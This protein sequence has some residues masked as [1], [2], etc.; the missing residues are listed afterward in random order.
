MEKG[1]EKRAESVIN[2]PLFRYTPLTCLEE[3][4]FRP[5]FS[6]QLIEISDDIQRGAIYRG[7]L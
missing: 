7:D 5:Y 2:R 6:L 3:T 1:D 4:V